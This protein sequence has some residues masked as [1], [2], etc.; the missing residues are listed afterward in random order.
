M[1]VLKLFEI[2]DFPKTSW[3]EGA[4]ACVFFCNYEAHCNAPHGTN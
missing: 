1:Y 3:K 4:V 2:L